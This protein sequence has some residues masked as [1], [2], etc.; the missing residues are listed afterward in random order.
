MSGAGWLVAA[1]L[2]LA[3]LLPINAHYGVMKNATTL[4][5]ALTIG[6]CTAWVFGRRW[7]LAAGTAGTALL[8]WPQLTH[9]RFVNLDVRTYKSFRW[10]AEQPELA[11][12]LI[13]LLAGLL[14]LVLIQGRWP[15]RVGWAVVAA[16]GPL[17]PLPESARLGIFV[18]LCGVWL[19]R[20]EHRAFYLVQSVAWSLP[21][22]FPLD[23]QAGVLG[24]PLATGLALF[25]LR[26]VSQR[27]WRWRWTGGLA[28]LVGGFVGLGW[29]MGLSVAGIDFGFLVRF[30][31]GDLHERLWWLVGL[32]VLVKVFIPVMLIAALAQRLLG[33]EGQII[34]ETASRAAALRVA[35]IGLCV[36]GWL[37]APESSAA[38][39]KLAHVIQDGF[40]WA[41]VGAMGALSWA[42][43]QR[44]AAKT[45]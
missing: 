19:F 32:G 13:C 38:G 40:Y 25:A 18:L 24:I 17:V 11:Q 44:G 42:A 27:D 39:A 10:M 29:T 43:L 36:G 12:A 34:F 26:Q 8:V 4:M 45:A 21:L 9:V 6:A 23:Q 7:W 14:A 33:Q 41:L 35:I 31:P 16:A 3:V 20:S 1:G 5:P 28:V 22:L 30:L 37:L 2:L 15:A